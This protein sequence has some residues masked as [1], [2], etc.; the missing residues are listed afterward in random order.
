MFSKMYLSCLAVF[1][2]TVYLFT[3]DLV[4]YYCSFGRIIICALL[5]DYSLSAYAAKGSMTSLPVL[6]MML[7]SELCRLS[8]FYESRR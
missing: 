5:A 4:G 8:S 1:L 2:I 3:S 7:F 6:V